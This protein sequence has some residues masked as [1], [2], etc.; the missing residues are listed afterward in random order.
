[1]NFNY[2]CFSVK[3]TYSFLVIFEC[4]CLYCYI[5]F[6]ACLFIF[7][8]S[9]YG[10]S[11]MIRWNSTDDPST[12]TIPILDFLCGI[13]MILTFKML[14]FK[15]VLLYYLFSVYHLLLFV[16]SLQL[17]FTSL[18]S[19][20]LLWNRRMSI[21]SGLDSSVLAKTCFR[22]S[23]IT[24]DHHLASAVYIVIVYTLIVFMNNIDN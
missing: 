7:H 10:F 8:S 15:T 9:A 1:M 3:K 17:L 21:I 5:I 6:I 14:L 24:L 18:V 16:N 23:S 19:Q 20:F 22:Y 4:D 13:I 2:I 12:V 11:G